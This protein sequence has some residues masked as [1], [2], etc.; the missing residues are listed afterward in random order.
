MPASFAVAVVGAA[1]A[2]QF[3][4]SA[5]PR[6]LVETR[7]VGPA[8]MG[9]IGR[10]GVL[11]VA[12]ALTGIAM[13]REARA[14]LDGAGWPLWPALPLA[15]YGNRKTVR[16]E[17]GPGVYAFEQVR[18]HP[19]TVRATQPRPPHLPRCLTSSTFKWESA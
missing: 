4:G 18:T 14:S 9:G 13:P 3:A 10:R 7:A 5:P 11:A 19:N 1:A 8:M 16:R 6:G 2:L 15:P 12:A 17:V